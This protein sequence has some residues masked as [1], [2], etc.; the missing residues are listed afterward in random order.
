[1]EQEEIQN[2]QVQIH[3]HE[4]TDVF[5]T[6]TI[7]REV[8]IKISVLGNCFGGK[9]EEQGGGRWSE[10]YGLGSKVGSFQVNKSHG[11]NGNLGQ[12]A[13]D[14]TKVKTEP[15]G[16][17]KPNSSTPRLPAPSGGHQGRVKFR[18]FRM[19]RVSSFY[20]ARIPG[21]KD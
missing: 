18:Q 16:P 2:Y 15:K 5:R 8:E 11:P 7:A 9:K 14:P 12:V 17:E 6:M 1:M 13:G 21:I 20:S 3:S 10:Q 19:K 4:T